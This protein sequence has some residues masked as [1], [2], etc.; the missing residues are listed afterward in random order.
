LL[1]VEPNHQSGIPSLHEVSLNQY[2]QSDGGH[3]S[4]LF[5]LSLFEHEYFPHQLDTFVP[6]VAQ[7]H[8]IAVEEQVDDVVALYWYFSVDPAEVKAEGFAFGGLL[9]PV[10]LAAVGLQ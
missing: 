2:A 3:S 8:Q 1:V 4:T 6:H 9:F 5:D 10:V 7:G